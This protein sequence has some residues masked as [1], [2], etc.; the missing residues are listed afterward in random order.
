MNINFIYY[1]PQDNNQV[2]CVS[3]GEIDPD[4]WVSQGYLLATVG[5]DFSKH[6][7]RDYTVTVTDGV[8]SGIS[9]RV[10]PFQPDTIEEDLIRLQK[11]WLEKDMAQKLEADTSPEAMAY[12]AK[13]EEK[14]LKDKGIK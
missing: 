7:T 14:K 12:K 6:I 4:W 8:V 3:T 13:K 1:D 11:A 2:M 5:S 10:N 9:P